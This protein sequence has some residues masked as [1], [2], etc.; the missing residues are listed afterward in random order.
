MCVGIESDPSRVR[1]Q[2]GSLSS[3]L[4]V[5]V[6]FED[7]AGS[8]HALT[9]GQLAACSSWNPSIQMPVVANLLALL[10]GERTAVVFRFTPQGDGVDYRIDDVYV[11]PHRH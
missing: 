8:V 11:D 3:S 4:R 1:A 5:E 9:I 6:L 2:H 10:P 7:A